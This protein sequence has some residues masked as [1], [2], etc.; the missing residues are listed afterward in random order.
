MLTPSPKT[1]PSRLDNIAQMNADADVNLFSLGFL[2]VVRPQLRLNLLGA[3]HSMDHGGKVYQ[4]CVTD[5][6]DDC[7]VMF[8][9][10][11]VG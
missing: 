8:S 6:F 9:S 5:G 3:L 2:G 1:S 7:A 4:E 11:P 10:P